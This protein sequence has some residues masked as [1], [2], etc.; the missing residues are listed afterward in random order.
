MP[1]SNEQPD[2]MPRW[3]RQAIF[4][5]WGTLVG[6][7]LTYVVARELRGLLTQVALALFLSFAMEPLVDRLNDR[8][9]NRGLAT[10]LTMLGVALFFVAFLTAMGSLVATQVRQLANDLPGYVTSA[11]VWT[12]DRFDVDIVTD[13]VLSALG[14][15][16][17]AS[18]YLSTVAD[19][20]V[21]VGAALAGILFQVLTVSLFAFYLTADGPRVRSAICSLLPPARQHEVLRAWELAITKT[22]AF[23]A[24]RFI[25]ATI[26]AF[27]HWVAFRVI[28]LPSAVALALWVGLVSQFIPVIGTYIAG[29]APA[30]IALGVE[31]SM[32]LWVVLTVVVYQQI[33]NYVIQPRVTAHSLSMHPAVAFAAV[34]AGTAIFGVP[35][36]LLALP[37][38]ATVQSFISAFIEHHDVVDNR[39]LTSR[40]KGAKGDPEA[41]SDLP[42]EPA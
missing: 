31:P 21:G 6:L 30:L 39:L 16:G 2:R 11:E 25:L 42:K 36:A 26:S 4:L 20:V 28:G 10:G 5:W 32:A 23:L 33:E 7:W 35:G 29:V 8:G 3:V 1:S 9:W 13:D 22:G 14:D 24:S 17:Q 38:L 40:E 41:S 37:F 15:G 27:T 18:E 34:L 19:N 12:E